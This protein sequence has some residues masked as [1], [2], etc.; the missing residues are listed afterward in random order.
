MRTPSPGATDWPLRTGWR[1]RA[2]QFALLQGSDDRELGHNWNTWEPVLPSWIAFHQAAH[3]K[4]GI[5]APPKGIADIGREGLQAYRAELVKRRGELGKAAELFAASGPEIGRA[6]EVLAAR[7]Y[8]PFEFPQGARGKLAAAPARIGALVQYAQQLAADPEVPLHA[9]EARIEAIGEELDDLNSLAN[10]VSRWHI[11]KRPAAVPP[12]PAA[13]DRLASEDRANLEEVFRRVPD[14]G[15]A[16]L[17]LV[18]QRPQVFSQVD[19]ATGQRFSAQLKDFVERGSLKAEDVPGFCEFLSRMATRRFDWRRGG[20]SMAVCSAMNS[21]FNH[22]GLILQMIEAAR[23]NERLPVR[24]VYDGDGARALRPIGDLKA[25]FRPVEATD[26]LPPASLGYERGFLRALVDE[27]APSPLT[28]PVDRFAKIC[29][30]T[31]V[32]L[33]KLTGQD[34]RYGYAFK[35][36]T[37]EDLVTI[38]LSGVSDSPAKVKRIF[39]TAKPRM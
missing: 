28:L 23:N 7:S 1:R 31:A 22:P 10:Q 25:G 5:A 21:V 12:D 26:E 39:E 19:S 6:A 2:F 15:K 17:Q 13:P 38:V 35:L 14:A 3:G 33:S 29:D 32:A 4:P 34:V 24:A 37:G 9:A 16:L 36:R 30:P 18:T 11:G 8:L 20:Y 27:L